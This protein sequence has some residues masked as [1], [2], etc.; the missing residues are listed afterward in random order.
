VRQHGL[1]VFAACLIVSISVI[2]SSGRPAAATSLQPRVTAVAGA[3]EIGYPVH[4]DVSP[5]LG[6]L[7]ETTQE[8]VSDRGKDRSAKKF[9]PDSKS[10]VAGSP[11]ASTPV[12]APATS[13]TFEGIGQGFSGPAGAFAVQYAPPDPNG[14]V[15][16]NH[17]VETVNVSF[18]IFDRTGTPIYG[19]AKINTLW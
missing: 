8:E 13:S 18:A 14:A 1:P 17:Y 5:P 6:T 4:M 10:G 12:S 15:G 9:K 7:Q 2:V 16:P 3:P 19:P 11:S